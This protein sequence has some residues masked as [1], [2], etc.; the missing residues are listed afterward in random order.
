MKIEREIIFSERIQFRSSQYF[1]KDPAID[2][3]WLMSFWWMKISK[4]KCTHVGLLTFQ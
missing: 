3:R 4:R 2:E 1:L